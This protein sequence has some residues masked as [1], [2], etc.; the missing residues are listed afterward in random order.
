MPETTAI[1]Q[2][3]ARRAEKKVWK[4]LK[5]PFLKRFLK[6][7]EALLYMTIAVVGGGLAGCECAWALAD[8]GVKVV[9]YE[10]K[11]RASSPAHSMEG[12][13]ELVC[14]NSLRSDELT[15]AVGLL[16]AEMR[17]AGSL[18][19][20]AAEASRVPAG[21]A[22]A[23]DREAFSAF[24][25]ERIADRPEIRLERREILG[26]DDP[27]LTDFEAVV[28]AAGPLAGEALAADLMRVVG[29]K[30][31]YFY[32]AVAP[33][34]AA[35]SV[36]MDKAFWGS[37]W[38]EGEGGDYLNC[39]MNEEEYKRFT[40]ALLAADKVPAREFEKEA[41]FEGCLPI[42]VMAERGEM[43][44]AFGPLKPVGFVDPKTGERPFAVLQLRMEN[45]ERTA[46][47][48]VGFQT[49]LTYGE[50][51]RVFRMI[52]GLEKA[53]FL[54]LGSIHRNTFVNAPKVLGERLEL[55]ARPGV[56]LAGQIT[57]VEGYV[58]SAA[59]GLWL[60]L[61]LGCG[62]PLPPRETALGALLGHLRSDA[63][64]FQPSNVNFGLM[65]G[66]KV[67]AKKARRRELYAA[68]AREAWDSWREKH[69]GQKPDAH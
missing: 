40:A 53:E 32:D 44:L 26:L 52:P 50:Q 36:D 22:L 56:H 7:P 67:R 9:L 48:L 64:H 63:K 4:I 37:R 39:P 21:K 29:E 68:R 69:A 3:A 8:C 19:M 2:R 33:I 15:A 45:R 34:V 38:E 62:L 5:K 12:L 60:G 55:L 23:V 27:A 10:M 30:A 24:I 66:L 20:A 46:F 16:K 1:V 25:T 11:P 17:D 51:K 57:G 14:S 43:T 54:R 47:N 49:K 41:H 65:P 31:L 61:H 28:V 59:C 6:P 42:E 35:D 18:V 58:E 13:G